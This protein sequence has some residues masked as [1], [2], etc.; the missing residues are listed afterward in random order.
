MEQPYNRR[1]CVRGIIY[2]NGKL[3]GQELKNK[4][5]TSRGFWCTPGGGL[6]PRES[7]IEGLRRE[8]IEE[9][10]VIPDIGGLLFI[11]Q[12]ADTINRTSHGEDEQ[13]EF[14]FHIKNADD[15]ESVDENAS[16][17]DEEI[18][19]YGFIN[20]AT[21]NILPKFLRQINIEDYIKNEHSPYIYTEFPD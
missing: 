9:T 19:N 14:F 3:F 4:D 12:F 2:K 5:G 20:P 15:F 21:D 6:D 11:Q 1:V 17:F 8:I 16:H 10:G 13:L 18:F 7:L